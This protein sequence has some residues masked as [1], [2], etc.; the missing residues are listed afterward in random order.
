METQR[1]TYDIIRKAVQ[2]WPTARRLKLIQVIIND[3]AA[4]DE[5]VREPK[6]TANKAL[7]LIRRYSNE[8]PPTDDEVKRILEEERMKKYG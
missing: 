4:D 1:L 3:I 6:Q 2:Q 5:P 8:P 7:G